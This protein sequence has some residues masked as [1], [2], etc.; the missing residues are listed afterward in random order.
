M[1]SCVCEDVVNNPEKLDK[2]EDK[3]TQDGDRTSLPDA[4]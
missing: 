1:I 3:K 2:E 4:L